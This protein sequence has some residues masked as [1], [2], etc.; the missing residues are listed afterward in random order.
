MTGPHPAVARVRLAVREVLADVPAGSTV[1]VAVSGGADSMALAAATAFEARAAPWECC[2]VLIDHQLQPD[3]GRVADEVSRRLTDIGFAQVIVRAV[4]VGSAGGPEAAARDARYEAIDGV[5]AEL[6]AV[7]VLLGHTRDDQAESVLLGLA[8]GSGARS[9]SGMPSSR[10][11]LRRPLLA[12]DRATTRSACDAE[13]L[14][15]WDDPH[16]DDEKYS[17]VR[18]RQQ[19]LPVLERELGPGVGAALARTARLVREDDSALEQWAAEVRQEVR[20]VGADGS[21]ALD[22]AELAT[23]P[24][25]V[26]RRVLRAE[27]LQSGVPGGDLRATHLSDL[28]S[29]VSHWRGQGPVHLPGGVRAVRD[30]GRLQLAPQ[31][32]AE[33]P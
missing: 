33:S 30:C 19:V 15:V 29:L 1:L 26:R 25:A 27:A 14:A 31:A 10:G 6:D 13:D 7:A 23:V 5:A 17:R 28:D 3:S 12:I 8:R 4:D 2:A 9:I 20:C 21:A 18:V 22:A 24:A 11:L 16:N 32:A